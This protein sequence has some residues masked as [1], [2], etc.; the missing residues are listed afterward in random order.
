MRLVWV[1]Q[2][3]TKQNDVLSGLPTHPANMLHLGQ[4]QHVSQVLQQDAS[5]ADDY[6]AAPLLAAVLH[7]ILPTDPALEPRL[8]LFVRDPR[9]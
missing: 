6:L 5:L 3:F 4:Q 7:Y 2:L 9:G 8:V 1:F